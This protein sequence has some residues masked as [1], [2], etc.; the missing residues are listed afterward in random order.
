MDLQTALQLRSKGYSLIPLRGGDPSSPD[1]KRPLI[2]WLPYQNRLATP[3]EIS[4]WG[5]ETYGLVTG[6]FS[7]VF[8]V[9]LD[10]LEATEAFHTQFSNGVWSKTRR[11][12]HCFFKW[13]DRLAKK[14]TTKVRIS[15]DRDTRGDGGY[16][17]LWDADPL[18]QAVELPPVPQFIIDQ[19]PD[20]LATPI[21]ATPIDAVLSGIREGN[22]NDSFMRVVSSMWARGFT[23]EFIYELLT[24]KAMAVGTPLSE[25]QTIINSVSRYARN[26]TETDNP[27]S[28]ESFLEDEAAISWICSPIL[29]DGILGFIAGLPETGKTWIA[30]DL[31][32]EVARGGLWLG[33]FQTASRKVLFID[34]ERFKGETQRR[35]KAVITGKGL[36]PKQLGNNLMIKCGT[37]TRLNLQPSF[38]AFRKILADNRPAL[39]I[40]DSF[41]TFHTNEENSRKDIQEV[42]E[43]V[44]QLRQ[45]FNCAFLFIDHENKGVFHEKENEEPPTA[46]RMAGSIAKPAAAELVLTVRRL[47]EGESMVYMTKSTLAPTIA[48]FSVR[49]ADLNEQKSSIKIEAH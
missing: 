8:V 30:I 20:K 28:V 26:V 16:V 12:Y 48:P 24:P 45:E 18:I 39:V 5:T 7:K 14:V 43:K 1:F 25:L 32:I 47:G 35:F 9:D 22:R 11:G 3:A 36:H 31:A 21:V 4:A 41:V 29:A 19:L 17:V 15:A 34:Q 38:D 49:V 13:D 6:P 42:L 23:K 33:K 44:K 40:V 10:S 46:L 27:Q 37:S 2:D